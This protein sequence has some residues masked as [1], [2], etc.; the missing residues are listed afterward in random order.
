MV[1]H[2]CPDAQMPPGHTPGGNLDL[3]TETLSKI[4]RLGEIG[5]SGRIGSFREIYRLGEIPESL[6]ITEPEPTA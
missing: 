3:E 6:P 5:Q 1:N 2:S 4:Y